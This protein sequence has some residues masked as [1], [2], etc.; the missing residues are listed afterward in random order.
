MGRKAKET[1]EEERKIIINL[2]NQCKSLCE[3]AK[4]V[5][6]P[7]STVQTVIDRF[8]ITKTLKNKPRGGAS[9]KNHASIGSENF[10]LCKKKSKN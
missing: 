4:F 5:N 2:H 3:I 10:K 7:R 1:S 9:I 6:R 8:S